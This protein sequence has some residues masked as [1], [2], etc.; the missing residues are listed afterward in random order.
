[1]GMSANWLQRSS[2][3][4]SAEELYA[5]HAR[6]AAFER[7]LPPWESARLLRTEGTFGN[8]FRVTVRA[9]IAGPIAAN[10]VAELFDVRPGQQFCDRQLQGPFAEWVHT[11]RMIPQGAN[12]ST[13]EDSIDYR[14][15]LG[16]VGSLFG[17]GL[18]RQR[19]RAM[20][21]YRHTL[22]ALDLA[23]HAR[24]AQAP[25]QT[26]A[27][28]G[29]T[30]LLGNP[31]ALF[32]ASG[33]HRVIRFVR[34]PGEPRFDGTEERRWDPTT[35]LPVELFQDVDTVIHLAG[36]GIAEGRWSEAKKER[37]RS[38]RVGPTTRLAE[39]LARSGRVKVLLSGSGAGIYGDRGDEWLTEA[40]T[41]GTGFLADVAQEW[42]AAT[43]PAQ[44]AGLR[45]VHLRTGVVLTPRGGAL[46]K[47]LPAFQAGGGAVLGS[48]TQWVPWI[49]LEDWLGIAHH[50]LHTDSVTGPV[51]AVAPN[52]V[53]NREFGRILARVLTRPYL[54]TVPAPML[55]GMF[56]EMA[57]AALLASTRAKPEK[58]LHQGF[59]FAHGELEGCLRFLLG[60]ETAA[61]A[62]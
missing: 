6:P 22:T 3:P 59:E 28:T 2:M 52:P 5:W 25:R 16:A 56:G 9:G 47:Q 30:G 31:L 40:S 60:R 19:L 62:R 50:A 49:G 15:P 20:F 39:A 46:G 44:K 11:H 35:E 17:S 4:V 33:G 23:R 1:M 7:L 57:D 32:L 10:W 43:E 24:F 51:L 13:L 26:I 27:I 36:E 48:G 34:K 8:N 37:I 58:I 61:Q 12:S 29:A 55:R 45:V 42:E 38:S 21:T 14:L 18:I 54:M 41:P 53:S